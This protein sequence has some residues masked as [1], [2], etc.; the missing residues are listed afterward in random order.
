MMYILQGGQCV[1]VLG[2]VEGEKIVLAQGEIVVELW[3]AGADFA[4]PRSQNMPPHA[5]PKLIIEWNVFHSLI[6]LGLAR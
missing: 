2:A 6:V 4:D 3:S 5:R 1:D